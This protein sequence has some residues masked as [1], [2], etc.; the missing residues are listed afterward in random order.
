MGTRSSF[1]SAR[2]E[3]QC[4]QESPTPALHGNAADCLQVR[5]SKSQEREIANGEVVPTLSMLEA[6]FVKAGV[7]LDPG[8]K[9][10]LGTIVDRVEDYETMFQREAEQRERISM[11]L[12][13]REQKSRERE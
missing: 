3:V 2:E 7:P 4:L 8:F 1:D 11:R 9:K 10:F 5:R 12:E 6:R 13:E